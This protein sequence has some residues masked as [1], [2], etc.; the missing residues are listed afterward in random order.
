MTFERTCDLELV[1][2][3]VTDPRIWPFVSDDA[4]GE[5]KDYRPT[6]HPAIWYV[7]V[8]DAD[9]FLGIFILTRQGAC[10]MEIHTCLL[11]ISWG[12]RAQAA[13]QGLFEWIWRHTECRRIISAVPEFNR[14]ALQFGKRCGMT[15]YGVNEQSFLKSGNA[16]GQILL[17]I[18]RPQGESPCQ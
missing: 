13:L 8:H 5:A 11:P 6:E 7:A 2:R 15:V 10:C 12:A 14:L 3:T 16:W 1:K 4:S 17:G 9:L 18:T